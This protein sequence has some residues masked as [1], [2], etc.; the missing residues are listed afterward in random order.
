MPWNKTTDYRLQTTDETKSPGFASKKAVDGRLWTV[1]SKKGFTLVEL[2]VVIS[3]I[4][5]LSAIGIVFYGQ[6][7]LSARDSKRQSD[8]KEIQNALEQYYTLN[9]SYPGGASC[10]TIVSTMT[11]IASYFGQ[12]VPPSDPRPNSF[13]APY[14]PYDY[15][16]CPCTTNSPPTRYLICTRL[17]SPQGK[18]NAQIGVGSACDGTWY[19][20]TTNASNNIYCAPSLSN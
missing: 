3:I 8:I 2:M 9:R 16:F 1:D 19:Q 10:P 17:E 4:A 6:A 13:P 15:T 14:S 18:A 20:G 11:T 7:E 12:G 5:L